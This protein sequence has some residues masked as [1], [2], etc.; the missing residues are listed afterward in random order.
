MFSAVLRHSLTPPLSDWGS[1]DWGVADE[2]GRNNH[3][4]V[5]AINEALKR[6]GLETWF[7]ADKLARHTSQKSVRHFCERARTGIS[8]SFPSPQSGNVL[9]EM[10]RGIDRSLAVAVFITE[11]CAFI[12]V[13]WRHTFSHAPTSPRNQLK[14]K[15]RSRRRPGQGWRQQ[16][17]GQLSHRVRLRP[18]AL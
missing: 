14:M 4:T 3:E 5:A 15:Y 12:L 1:P 17:R 8:H 9:N 11:R 18:G 13:T 10:T 7:D 2:L 6:R 16:P